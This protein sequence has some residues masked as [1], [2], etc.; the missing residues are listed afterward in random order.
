M[1]AYLEI[2]YNVAAMLSCRY[3]GPGMVHYQRRLDSSDRILAIMANGGHE[4]LPP[5]PLVPYAMS[6]STTVIYRAFRDGERDMEPTLR[7]LGLCCDAL[8][9]LSRRW[10]SVKAISRMTKKVWRYTKNS[11][12]GSAQVRSHEAA[13]TPRIVFMANGTAVTA[14]ERMEEPCSGAA[15]TPLHD[16]L[17]TRANVPLPL[18][19]PP[20][21]GGQGVE[22]QMDDHSWPPLSG[23]EASV[24]QSDFD[25]ALHDMFDFSMPNVFRDPLAWQ[26][27]QM[28]S[29]DESNVTGG[30]YGYSNAYI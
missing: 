11:T 17:S 2:W 10:A 7:D 20:S 30:E 19:A 12:L 29:N 14:G 18:D 25:W 13:H 26:H 15:N 1:T 21:E 9:S 23:A 28:T 6:M 27:L 22:S 24:F 5:L 3:S 16:P 4:K 8:E